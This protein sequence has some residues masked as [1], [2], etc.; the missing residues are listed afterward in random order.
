MGLIPGVTPKRH[1]VPPFEGPAS[2][3]G[4]RRP[5][6]RRAPRAMGL[7]PVVT[8][9]RHAVPP[10]EGP[11]SCGGRRRPPARRAPRA[12]GLIPVVTP[13]RHAVPPF[14][15]P[16]SRGSRK[17]PPARRA[18]RLA[19]PAQGWAKP[20]TVHLVL[21]Q[22][23]RHSQRTRQLPGR[24]VVWLVI[25]MA[26]FSDLDIPATWRQI[27]GTLRSLWAVASGRR[28][29]VKSPRRGNVLVLGRF[30]GCSSAD[31]LPWQPIGP[32]APSTAACD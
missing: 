29:P 7:I 24:A 17:R 16:A 27:K 8:P 9:K 22:T 23:G 4:R 31:P 19:S 5:P 2:C 26:V 28:P 21:S 6:A 15:G 32:A 30:A 25:A 3:G 13:K 20:N 18:P 10:F 11:A 1:A 14:E 12:M